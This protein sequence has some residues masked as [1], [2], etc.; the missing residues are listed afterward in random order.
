M[1]V[2]AKSATAHQMHDYLVF[3]IPANTGY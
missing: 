2:A 3:K 1:V